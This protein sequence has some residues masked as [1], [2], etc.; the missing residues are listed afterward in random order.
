MTQKEAEEGG[1]YLK[2]ADSMRRYCE[3]GTLRQDLE[4]LF[5]R[6]VFNVICNNSD[7]HLRNHGFLYSDTGWRLSPAYDVVPQPD[8]GPEEVRMLHLTVGPQGRL[9]KI[10]NAIAA[11]SSFGLNTEEA[12]HV[13][14][15][16]QN[17]FRANWG[18][19]FGKAGV[20]ERIMTELYESFREL[21]ED[22]PQVAHGASMGM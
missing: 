14:L 21:Y 5:R 8:M 10:E 4:E 1:S 12:T 22:I 16:V 9:A 13:A 17:E 19:V 18:Q 6:V 7:D 2:I 15:D 3:V 20:P 11:C